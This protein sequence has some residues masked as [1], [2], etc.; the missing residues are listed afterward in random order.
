MVRRADLTEFG[1]VITVRFIQR[2]DSLRLGPVQ[3]A[4]IICERGAIRVDVEQKDVRV[5][6]REFGRFG[7]RQA[8][9]ADS[10]SDGFGVGFVKPQLREE[11]ER[12]DSHLG[13]GDFI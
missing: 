2:R 7:R 13:V 1:R 11:G 9:R 12:L 4:V 8:Q 3:F 6:R 5:S 10:A